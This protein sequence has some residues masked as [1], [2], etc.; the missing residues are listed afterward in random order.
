MV[1]EKGAIRGSG[2]TIGQPASLPSSQFGL[3]PLSSVAAENP[4]IINIYINSL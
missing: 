3:Q 1:A 4:D 2:S